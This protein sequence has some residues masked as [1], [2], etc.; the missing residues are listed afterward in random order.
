MSGLGIGRS[1]RQNEYHAITLPDKDPKNQGRYKVHIPELHPLI[2]QGKGIWVK[3]HVHRWRYN[4]CDDY[5]YGEYKPVQPGT[6]VMVKFYEDDL[7]TGYV[8]RIISDQILNSLLKIGVT[9]S[10]GGIG[11]TSVT[12]DVGET[13]GTGGTGGPN[14]ITTDRDDM[15]LIYKTPKKHNMFLVLEETTGPGLTANLIP[16]SIH[17]YFNKLRSTMIIN[18]DGIHWYTDD[19]RG[20]TVRKQNSELVYEDEKVQV[21]G[22]RHLHIGK[23]AF[24][25]VGMTKMVQVT[26]FSYHD[27]GLMSYTTAALLIALDSP[28][29][30]MN[31][32]KAKFP[33]IANE[34]EGEDEII[35]QNKIT[36]KLKPEKTDKA[37]LELK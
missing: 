11:S 19:N 26:G 6:I 2:E 35:K 8:H 25:S 3:N 28:T 27:A 13:G 36:Q 32:K 30:W 17:F 22:N 29:I 5:F 4:G 20:V 16:N 24:E 9:G 34:N 7:N 23:N 15:Y 1:L 21:K 10:T 12:G 31:S 37:D 14:L 33:K 18:E